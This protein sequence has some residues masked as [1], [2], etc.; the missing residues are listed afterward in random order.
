MKTCVYAGSFDPVTRGHLDVIKRAAQVFDRVIVAVGINHGKKYTF[1]LD[2]RLHMLNKVKGCPNVDVQTFERLLADFA[3]ESGATAVVKGVRNFADYDYEKLLAE[4]GQTQQ[5]GVDT[6]VLNASPGLQHVSSSAAKEL[7]K[8]HGLTHEYVPLLVK[9]G[10]EHA[11]HGQFVIG[12]TGEIAMGK[13]WFSLRLMELLQRFPRSFKA[14]LADSV[15]QHIDLD[16]IGREILTTRSEKV[17]ADLRETISR[18]FRVEL[19][20][21]GHVN[22]KS[23]GDLVFG[24]LGALSRLNELMRQPILTRIRGQILDRPGVIILNGALLVEAGLLPLCNNNL[25][26]VESSSFEQ[27]KSLQRRGL[28]DHQINRRLAS[29]LRT[30]DKLDKA[31]EAIRKE[32]HGLLQLYTNDPHINAEERIAQTF[33][34]FVNEYRN[35]TPMEAV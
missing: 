30:S 24:D 26:V 25:V 17:Y 33:R 12:V 32:G 22:R 10:L 34:L 27:A 28:S 4:I 21:N 11:I 19:L 2:Q 3:Y 23:L 29:Q 13:S 5:R 18:E 15:V 14:A 20:P 35:F 6:F 1:S 8:Y 9:Q 7:C 16:A 31:T